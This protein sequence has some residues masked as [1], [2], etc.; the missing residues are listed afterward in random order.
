MNP[1]NL[2]VTTHVTISSSEPNANGFVE[3]RLFKTKEKALKQFKTWRN[4][5]LECRKAT[6]TPYVIYS[7]TD[8][9][10]HCTWD[11]DNEGIILTLKEVE[12]A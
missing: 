8:Q 11:A 9:T 12:V 2:F 5:E 10:F 3:V 7:D 1:T 6:D 4:D